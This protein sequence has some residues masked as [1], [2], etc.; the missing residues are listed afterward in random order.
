MNLYSYRQF[1]LQV[2]NEV[3]K[4]KSHVGLEVIQ[5]INFI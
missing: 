3:S 5:F 2:T 1:V 4:R